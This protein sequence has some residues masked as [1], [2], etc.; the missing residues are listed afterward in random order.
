M[1]TWGIHHT[2]LVVYDG[3]EALKFYRDG[4]GLEV[5][6]DVEE[7]TVR[8]ARQVEV[9]DAWIRCIWLKTPDSNTLLELLEYK[10]PKGN[11]FNLKCNDIGAPH[12]SFLVD[13]IFETTDKLLSLGYKATTEPLDVDENTQPGAKTVYFHDADGIV[14]EIFQISDERR[15]AMKFY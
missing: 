5:V 2:S 11:S 10:N 14:V 6:T 3:D 12:V 8:L 9:K 15:K 7:K 4:L 1:G 13:N